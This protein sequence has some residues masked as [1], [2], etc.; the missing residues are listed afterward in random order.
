MGE[1]VA[2]NKEVQ[3]RMFLHDTGER[4]QAVSQPMD[5]DGSL[6][7]VR[8]EYYPVGN[9]LQYP[10]KWGRKK[11]ALLLVEHRIEEQKKIIASAQEELTKLELCLGDVNEWSNTD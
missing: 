10:K 9:R 2:F 7:L 1:Q 3:Q 8:K 4:Y 5:S 11:A 6:A